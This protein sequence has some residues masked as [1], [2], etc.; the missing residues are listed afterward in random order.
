M[1][2]PQDNFF[3]FNMPALSGVQNGLI[4]GAVNPASPSM[5]N[6]VFPGWVATA[7]V[8]IGPNGQTTG[9]T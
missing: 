5:I 2:A 7:V 8:P 1:V 4:T 3:S 6:P 9:G